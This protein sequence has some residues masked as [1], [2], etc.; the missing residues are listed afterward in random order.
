MTSPLWRHRHD[1][2]IM[3]SLLRHRG[4]TMTS[5]LRMLFMMSP[6]I[7]LFLALFHLAID[8]IGMI[9]YY[10]HPTKVNIL[11]LRTLSRSRSQMELLSW[12]TLSK[13][14]SETV[15]KS[16]QLAIRPFSFDRP[17]WYDPHV[18]IWPTRHRA[19]PIFWLVG[20]VEISVRSAMILECG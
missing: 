3:A 1:A 12:Q 14:I 17:V 2:I 7:I 9:K 18:S 13:S 15:E 10:F 20:L 5:Y 19:L 11:R 4:S 6:G 8:W 16:K